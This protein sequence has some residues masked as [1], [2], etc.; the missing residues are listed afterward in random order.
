MAQS[1]NIT[2]GHPIKPD[3]IPSDS[4]SAIGCG[5]ATKGVG[6]GINVTSHAFNHSEAKGYGA[7]SMGSGRPRP[8]SKSPC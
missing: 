6:H 3:P 8:V 7:G 1:K 5:P 4:R 2:P